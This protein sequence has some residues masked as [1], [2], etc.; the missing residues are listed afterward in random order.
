M[1]TCSNPTIRNMEDDLNNFW[2]WKMTSIFILKIKHSL[3]NFFNRNTVHTLTH[4]HTHTLYKCTNLLSTAYLMKAE[5]Q[6]WGRSRIEFKTRRYQWKRNK[7]NCV[8]ASVGGGGW[9]VHAV[10]HDTGQVV[11]VSAKLCQGAMVCW[12]GMNW[13][14]AGG[15]GWRLV[16]DL[17]THAGCEHS[18]NTWLSQDWGQP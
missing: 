8:A 14:M 13:G 11:T 3:I 2:K 4:S 16:R 5:I 18:K 1:K 6:L 12:E 9:L 17:D 7:S 10:R 15:G